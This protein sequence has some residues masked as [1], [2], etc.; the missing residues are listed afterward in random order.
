MHGPVW[1]VFTRV[2]SVP[3]V[4][5][6]REVICSE[7]KSVDFFSFCFYSFL[8]SLQV[9]CVCACVFNGLFHLC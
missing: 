8:L 1:C 3:K 9:L 6:A 2:A 4:C 5:G 7:S